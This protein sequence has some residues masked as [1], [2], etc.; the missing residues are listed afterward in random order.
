[1]GLIENAESKM[2][3]RRLVAFAEAQSSSAHPPSEPQ[4]HCERSRLATCSA[5]QPTDWEIL[6]WMQSLLKRRG[7]TQSLTFSDSR[8]M[9]YRTNFLSGWTGWGPKKHEAKGNS[10]REVISAMMIADGWKP[11][12]RDEPRHE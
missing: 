1:M 12:V 8:D 11:N 3:H 10:V 9:G 2:E 6:D 5:R 4:G 7:A